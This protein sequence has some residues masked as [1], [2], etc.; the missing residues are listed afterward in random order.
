MSAEIYMATQV[1]G[2]WGNV[3]RLEISN[4]SIMMAHP[5]ISTD[6]KT[7]YFVSDRVGGLGGKDIWKVSQEGG[8]WGNP[9]NMG[10]EVN[11]TGDEMF[12]FYP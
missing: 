7:L 8:K 10:A 2:V 12:P 11:T 1:A 9:E 4:D 3:E 5:S 6:G